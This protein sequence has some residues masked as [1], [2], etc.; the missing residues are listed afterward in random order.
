MPRLLLLPL[1]L[2]AACLPTVEDTSL[3]AFSAAPADS[4]APAWEASGAFAA[5]AG[6]E[7]GDWV[8]TVGAA[9]WDYHSPSHVD[10]S[11][12]VGEDV[13]I[14][15]SEEYDVLPTIRIDDAVGVRYIA[16]ASVSEDGTSFFGHKVWAF[17]EILGKGTVV[18]EYDEPGSVR[19]AEVVVTADDGEHILLAGEPAALTIDGAAWRVTVIAAFQPENAAGMKCSAPDVLALE[20]VRTDADPGEPLIR[21]LEARGPSGSCG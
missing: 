12:L 1:V 2:V 18:N 20:L 11:A 21:P 9:S 5:T 6:A 17:G 16:S 15:V 19:F 7:A 10:F 14:V 13:E 8:V 3:E 4:A